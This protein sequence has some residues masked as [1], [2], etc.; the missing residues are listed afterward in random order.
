MSANIEVVAVDVGG[1]LFTDGTKKLL[2]ELRGDERDAIRGILRGS[3]ARALKCGLLSAAGFWRWAESG[4]PEGWGADRL[5]QAWFGAYQPIV[6][7]H[8]LVAALRANSRPPRI[9]AFSGNFGERVTWLEQQFAFRHLF[10]S[11]VWSDEVGATKP[12]QV[13]VDT[14][15][16][17]CGVEPAQIVYLDDKASALAPAQARGIHGVLVDSA[18]AC[19]TALQGWGLV[20]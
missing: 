2:A 8:E 7:I 6:A 9:V 16:E 12:S 1:V 4:L 10:D 20:R 19:R 15:I 3:Q 13:F 14:L 18:Q 5:R 11:E 17:H